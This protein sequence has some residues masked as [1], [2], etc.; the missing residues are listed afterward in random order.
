MK[1]IKS[2]IDPQVETQIKA[3]HEK[4]LEFLNQVDKY[5]EELLHSLNERL[6]KPKVESILEESQGFIKNERNHIDLIQQQLVKVR[7]EELDLRG[8]VFNDQLI[9]FVPTGD[10]WVKIPVGSIKFYD[11]K[12]LIERETQTISYRF[13]E[14][15]KE[16]LCKFF[17][18][19][20]RFMLPSGEILLIETSIGSQTVSQGWCLCLFSLPIIDA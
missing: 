3:V 16:K 19:S 1:N 6:G 8:R 13:V 9:D 14:L 17:P 18:F 7:Q 2:K 12:S 11:Y 20:N 15:N 5:Q 4:R 10:P